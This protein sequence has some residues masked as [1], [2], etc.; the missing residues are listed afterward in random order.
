[1]VVEAEA[2]GAFVASWG[3]WLGLFPLARVAVVVFAAAYQPHD[4]GE[5]L[6]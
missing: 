1:M 6:Q 3:V 4:P 2:G 5:S